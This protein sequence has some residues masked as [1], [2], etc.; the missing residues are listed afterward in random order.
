MILTGET[1]TTQRKTCVSATVTPYSLV[2]YRNFGVSPVFIF[3]VE[4]TTG[5]FLTS[6]YGVITQHSVKQDNTDLTMAFFA[7][8][9]S[10]GFTVQN[11][12]FH[13]RP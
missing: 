1:R 3:T 5:S 4:V 11:V 2:R 12:Q 10:L 7:F 9:M 13:L 6:I 8:R